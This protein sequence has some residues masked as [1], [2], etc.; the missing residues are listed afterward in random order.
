MKASLWLAFVVACIECGSIQTARSE[1]LDL[2]PGV[3]KAEFIDET[4]PFPSCHAA[5]IAETPKGALAAQCR[6]LT[7]RP[8]LATHAGARKRTRRIQLPRDHSTR[9]RTRPHH[10]H[11]ETPTSE[12]RRP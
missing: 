12:T 6:G 11:L 9:R 3:L 10:L 8:R 4:A 5:T 7:R 2:P 1:S